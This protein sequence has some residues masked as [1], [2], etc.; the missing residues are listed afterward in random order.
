MRLTRTLIEN[1]VNKIL[2]SVRSYDYVIPSGRDVL[3]YPFKIL[4]FL[5]LTQLLVFVSSL[6]IYPDW[7]GERL[8]M[9]SIFTVGICI[10]ASILI[11]G[12]TYNNVAMYLCLDLKTRRDSILI[13][14]VKRKLK[15]YLSFYFGINTMVSIFYLFYADWGSL[16]VGVS[17]FVTTMILCIVFNMS[18]SRYFTPAV[19]AVIGKIK[20]ILSPSAP[21]V[22][23]K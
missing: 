4:K 17:Y 8:L 7:S 12:V 11:I 9:Q 10:F 16:I 18:I 13:G 5:Y 21:A 19:F 6:Y 22:V 15:L 3:A 23:E 14:E 2:E 20:D 1:D